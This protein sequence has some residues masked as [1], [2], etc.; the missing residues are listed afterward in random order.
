MIVDVFL[1]YAFCLSVHLL[2]C[3][4]YFDFLYILKGNHI[5]LGDEMEVEIRGCS[6]WAVEVC[7]GQ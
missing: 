7:F 5:V 2:I 4:F 6:I 3:L 1:T